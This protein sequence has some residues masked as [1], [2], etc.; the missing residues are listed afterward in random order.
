MSIQLDEATWNTLESA[1]IAGCRLHAFMSG[2][3]LRVIRLEDNQLRGYGE[4]PH[5]G[6]AMCHAAED[7]RAGGRPYKEVYGKL[8]PH[9]LTGSSSTDSE[10]DAWLRKG[11]S[12]DARWV[13]GEFIFEMSGLETEE[14]DK[15]VIA[16]WT[17]GES[18]SWTSPRGVTRIGRPVRFANGDVG[19]SIRVQSVPAGMSEGRA[20][21]Y[22]VTKMG[23]ANLR[24]S[25]AVDKAIEAPGLEDEDEERP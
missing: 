22:S 14:I 3:G 4:A 2:G 7:Y 8:Y 15:D 13:S 5:V 6:E 9:Y 17:A 12:F 23:R 16:R 24:L 10:L 11:S 19:C 25:H 18:F 21:M 20:H 1:L